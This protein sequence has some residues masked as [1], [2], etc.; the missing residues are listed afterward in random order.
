M[1][2]T[3]V[4]VLLA[5]A[6]LSVV[7]AV[8]ASVLG[9]RASFLAVCWLPMAGLLLT[10][11]LHHHLGYSGL[12]TLGATLAASTALTALG[13]RLVAKGRREQIAVG[14][15]VAGTVIAALPLLLF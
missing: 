2:T 12:A 4:Y 8:A 13:W 5:A 6:V 7:H 1:L 10:I 14:A 15:L 11:G 3:G 9:T